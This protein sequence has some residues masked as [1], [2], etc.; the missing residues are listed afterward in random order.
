[1]Q[2]LSPDGS[3][4][5]ILNPDMRAVFWIHW[6]ERFEYSIQ[7]GTIKCQSAGAKTLTSCHLNAKDLN[8]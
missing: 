6:I 8:V 1:M 3:I 4:S 2:S 5:E 7:L